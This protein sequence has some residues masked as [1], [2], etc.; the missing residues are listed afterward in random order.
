VFANAL[1]ALAALFGAM[2]HGMRYT[3]P[4]EDTATPVVFLALRLG[5]GHFCARWPRPRGRLQP[6]PI[7]ERTFSALRA[8]SIGPAMISGRI[9]QIAVFPDD[10]SH[11]MIA[12][13]AGNI[14][15]TANG[16]GENNSQRAAAYGDGVYKSEEL[17]HLPQRGVEEFGAHRPHRGGPARFQRGLRRRAGS[18]LERRRRSRPLQDH[19]RRQDVVAEPHQSGRLHRLH[20]PHHGSRQSRCPMRTIGSRKISDTSN[21]DAYAPQ[22]TTVPEPLRSLVC[23]GPVGFAV[24]AVVVDLALARK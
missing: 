7:N 14:F 4:H 22:R 15:M 12:L 5:P 3:S 23:G 11:Y 1:A 18:T 17:P 24:P 6:G 20:R 13:A 2:L 19:G 10:S 8:R 9:L 21:G 16:S